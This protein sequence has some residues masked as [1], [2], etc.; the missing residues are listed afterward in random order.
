MSMIS[1]VAALDRQHA[2]GRRGTMPWHLPDDLRRFKR[3]TLDKPVLMGRKTAESI[4]RALPGRRNLVLTRSGAAPYEGQ[5][6]VRNLEQAIA[7]A[8]V[9]ELM[10][11]GGGE[12]YALALPLASR[13]YLTHVDCAAKGADTFFPALDRSQ[14]RVV[15][16]EPHPA[17]AQHAHAMEFVDYVRA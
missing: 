3:L 9:E 12:I 5:V 8:G 15:A 1:L 6:I 17:D 16:R 7:A 14:W 2:I 10:V 4:G 11:I 13:L